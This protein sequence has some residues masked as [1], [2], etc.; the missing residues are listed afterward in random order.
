MEKNSIL[1]FNNRESVSDVLNELLKNGTQQLIHQV[2]EARLS[3]YL[4]QY[5]RLI[6]DGRVALVCNGYLL[7]REILTV[8]GPVSVRIPK[9]RLKDGEALTF[10]STLVPPYV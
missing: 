2:L 3:E 5:Q 4:S 6:V 7:K 9:V 1:E 10:R 8:I